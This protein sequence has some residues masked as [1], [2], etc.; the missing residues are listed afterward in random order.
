MTTTHHPVS[1]KSNA[2]KRCCTTLKQRFDATLGDFET[3]T[4]FE[5]WW[6]DDPNEQRKVLA[7][8]AFNGGLEHAAKIV[9]GGH[10]LHDQAPAKLFSIEVA[11]AIRKEISK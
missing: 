10:F 9:E 3:M 8:I 7:E 6:G 4:A 11:E 1:L 5:Q 2:S